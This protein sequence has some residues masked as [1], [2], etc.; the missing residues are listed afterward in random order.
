MRALLPGL[1]IG[2]GWAFAAPAAH[3]ADLG[4][5]WLRGSMPAYGDSEPTGAW[6]GF[7]IGV[8][9]GYSNANIDFGTANSSQ[10]AYILRNLAVEQERRISGATVLPERDVRGGNY[11]FL[12]GYNSQWEDVV[13]GVELG[14]TRLN[15]DATASDSNRFWTATSNGYTYNVGLESSAQVKLTD[16]LTFR[17][18]AGYDLG[19]FL[20][21]ATLGLAV[22]RADVTR[23]ANVYLCEDTTGS[24]PPACAAGLYGSASERKKDT[25]AVGIAAG[26]GLDILLTENLFLRGEYEYVRFGSFENVNADLHTVRGAVAAKF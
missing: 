6:G 24:T 14:Y 12:V 7:Y 3:A 21:Y 15:L 25:Y 17:G 20:P 19:N 16:Y 8:Q 10:I 1:V 9:G 18:R 2:L 4:D 11:G 13:L 23:S 5:S 26:L 22:G